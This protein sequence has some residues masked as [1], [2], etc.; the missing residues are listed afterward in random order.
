MSIQLNGPLNLQGDTNFLNISKDG[1]VELA[2][3]ING[4][5][6]KIMI[7]KSP[8]P[9]IVAGEYTFTDTTEQGRIKNNNNN[10]YFELEANGGEILKISSD[11]GMWSLMSSHPLGVEI[12][13]DLDVQIGW[14]YTAENGFVSN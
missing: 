12:P 13:A 5:V 6:E 8:L 10:F 3:I 7:V 2:F 4:V 11:E 9:E 1:L 14:T